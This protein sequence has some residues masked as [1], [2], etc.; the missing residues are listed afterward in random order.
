V[1]LRD[2]AEL[3]RAAGLS[4]SVSEH[5]LSDTELDAHR[6]AIEDLLSSHE[7]YPA[8]AM[9]P[10]G[11]VVALN[12]QCALLNPGIEALTPEALVDAAVGPGP[13]R[14]AIVNFAGVAHA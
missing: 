7:P 13:A 4:T 2:R 3:V 5:R 8:C 9:D 11:R 6:V 10:Y 14:N 12:G 1:A